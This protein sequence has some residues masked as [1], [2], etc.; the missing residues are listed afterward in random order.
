MAPIGEANRW[1][2]WERGEA[3]PSRVVHS[4]VLAEE[5]A[6]LDAAGLEAYGVAGGVGGGPAGLVGDADRVGAG[7]DGVKDDVAAGVGE[8]GRLGGLEDAV[9]VEVEVDAAVGEA[10][11]AGILD[12]VLVGVVED[13]AG[14]EREVGVAEEVAARGVVGGDVD[15]EVLAGVGL[16]GL[17]GGDLAEGVRIRYSRPSGWLQYPRGSCGRRWR[18][19]RCRGGV[20]ATIVGGRTVYLNP[21][22]KDLRI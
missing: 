4:G 11:F 9:A 15:R 22:C 16:A 19:V 14:D 5:G 6:A 20:A 2:P 17:E 12:A 7:G 1:R 3:S 18:P 21:E 8:D 10:G 13:D